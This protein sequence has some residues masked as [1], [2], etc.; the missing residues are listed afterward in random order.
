MFTCTSR[1][2]VMWHIETRHY[3]S[4]KSS[5][6]TFKYMNTTHNEHY[7]SQQ[8]IRLMNRYLGEQFVVPLVVPH[9]VAPW[10]ST[11]QFLIYHTFAT[12]IYHNIN[13]QVSNAA[14]PQCNVTAHSELGTT[15][16]IIQYSERYRTKWY[17]VQFKLG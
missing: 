1:R 3:S 6:E 14:S 13:K 7:S 11:S 10:S 9:H 2:W 16:H 15:H 12:L 4:L 17:S 5:L 8:T